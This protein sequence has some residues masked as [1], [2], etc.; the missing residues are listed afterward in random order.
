MRYMQYK[1]KTMYASI[2]C[3]AIG[4][5]IS[6]DNIKEGFKLSLKEGKEPYGQ[7]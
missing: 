6:I 3:P 4:P 2:A 1:G 7:K 5:D